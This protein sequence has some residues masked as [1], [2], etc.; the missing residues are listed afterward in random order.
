MHKSLD[1]LHE[2]FPTLVTIFT[3]AFHEKVTQNSQLATDASVWLKEYMGWPYDRVDNTLTDVFNKMRP[4]YDFLECK[5]LL[6]MSKVFLQNVTFNENGTISEAIGR[7][8]F[9]AKE[10][11][12]LS[13][14][15]TF[16]KVLQQKIEPF[17]NDLEKIPYIH[18]HLQT[19]WE[20]RSIDALYK[21]IEKLLP[22]KFRQSLTDRISIYPGS[23]VIK[24]TVLDYTADSLIKYAQGKLQFMHL[25]GIFSL[26]INDHAVLQEDENINFTF[27][28]ALHEAVT[29]GHNEAVEFLLQLETVNIDHTNEEGKTAL[30]LACERGHD[31]IVHSLLSAEA[32]V[33]LQD[34][35]GWT[36]LMR[37]SEH[38]HISII[39]MLLQANANPQLKKSNGSNALMIASG[40]GNYEVVELLISIGVDYKYQRE[41][42]WNAFMFACQKGHTQIVE[43]L[44]KEQVD[45]NVQNKDGWNAFMSACKNG[46]TQIVE[47][48][49]KEQVDPNVQKEDGCNAFM[50]ACQNGHTQ[51]V[52]LLLKE[53]VDPNVQKEDGCNA[54]M[55]ACQNGHTQIVELLLKE[56]VDPNIQK[57]DGWNAFMFACQKGH[58]QIVELLLKEQVD[59]NVQDKDGW[60]AFMSACQNGHTQIVELLLKEQ[61]DP[62][63]QDKD[64]VNA[65]MLA[66]QNGHTQIVELLLKEQVDP[67]VQ[68]KDGVNAFMVACLNGC[69]Q[70]VELLLKEQV[71]PNVQN[72]DGVNAFMLACLNGCTQIV[73]LLLK[74][75]VDPNVQN[76]DGVNAFMVACLNG[77]TQIVELLLKEQVDPNVQ[78]KDGWNAFMVACENGRTQIV[79][80]LLKEQVD[81]NV[82]NKD[83]WNAFMVACLNGRT[84]IVELLLKEQVDPNVQNKDGVNAFMS[85]CQN[86]HIQIVEQLLKE[87][88]D[89]NVQK[90]DGWNA[91]MLACLNGHTQIVELLLK[92]QVDPNVQDKDGWNAFMSA[93]K[94]G[95]TQIVE[96]LL[97]EQVDPN[98]QKE[99][100][101]NAFMSSCKNGHTQ[102]VELLLKEQVDPNVQ[103]EDGW[104][105]FMLACKN[106]HTQIVELLLK[107]QVDP[108]VK[109]L[110]GT[111]A[112][113][114]ACMMETDNSEIVELLLKAGA[115]PNVQVESA[116][117]P[118]ING[119]TALIDVCMHGHLRTVQLL[120][121]AGANPNLKL[122]MIEVSPLHFAVTLGYP[123]ILK[124][125]IE[126]GANVNDCIAANPQFISSG[127]SITLSITGSPTMSI[128]SPKSADATLNV[129]T[130]FGNLSITFS[131]KQLR[132][133]LIQ[134]A[135]GLLC[136]KEATGKI[137]ESMKSMITNIFKLP[138]EG[139]ISSQELLKVM[140]EKIAGD[141]QLEIL[142]MLSLIC[143][144]NDP[145]TLV[146]A[147]MSGSTKVVDLL[148]KAGYDPLKPLSSSKFFQQVIQS[149]QQLAMLELPCP[150]LYTACAFGQLKVVQLFLNVTDSKSVQCT[151]LCEIACD[152]GHWD[153]LESLLQSTKNNDNTALHYVLSSDNQMITN[154]RLDIIQLFLKNN[155]NVNARDSDGLTPLMIASS[156]G[157]TEAVLLLLE[158]TDLNLKD[159]SGMTALMYAC[160]NGHCGIVEV[161][162]KTNNV[163]TT[164]IDRRGLSAL[165]HA[166]FGQHNDT[167]HVFLSYY[168]PSEEEIRRALVS[169]CCRGHMELIGFFINKLMLTKL[170]SNVVAACMSDD[171]DYISRAILL[172]PD[173]PL[174]ESTGLTPLMLATSC[175]SVGVVQ[176]LV[177]F[178][179]D[180]NKQDRYLKYSPLLYAV[181]GSKSVAMVQYLLDHGANVNVITTDGQTPL[182]IAILKKQNDI[183]KL[184][185]SRGGTTYSSPMGSK[186]K[187]DQ[188]SEHTKAQI[189]KAVVTDIILPCLAGGLST[190]NRL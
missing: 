95:H 185:Q 47:L 34:N 78:N 149:P 173:K 41:D 33:N 131:I 143:P 79:E 134:Y 18:I 13:T 168:E 77:R 52:E 74:E 19:D 31:D 55:L 43:L 20:E 73:E 183:A 30:M 159:S 56:Q 174:V 22:G 123:M 60:N 63:V 169:A 35:N 86:G 107:E 6:D 93:C 40:Y 113:K 165:S 146:F 28:L 186:V 137:A 144:D 99:D 69:T 152:C 1:E 12:K 42:G 130:N 37:A 88:V 36:A 27:E 70:I 108:N 25:I 23:I 97:K 84:Q 181:S 39:N 148:L 68:N 7:H 66:C 172:Q 50:L 118:F 65:F 175:G 161:L 45:P 122:R 5:L 91:F 64:G 81:P 94:N 157:F 117:E 87:Q 147:A 124:E 61:V 103:K 125:L 120:L 10:L 48:L 153:I 49:L 160:R 156:K 71:D 96:L 164:I 111:T 189:L 104:N 58:T 44:L 101:W 154:N 100:G 109:S 150:S 138:E 139:D 38:N 132:F 11:R 145:A 188:I 9:K 85:A 190:F 59:P 98:V 83:G 179:A 110:N 102:I 46:H 158:K 151:S 26:Y 177:E 57:E 51:I 32:N 128:T 167:V 155:V 16:R 106:G 72:K 90:E 142:Q 135:V 162:L 15:S 82:Q 29:A 67:N 127:S 112:L 129:T 180:V 105:A 140:T 75:Q 182:D 53:Q 4:Y 121:K 178:E 62:N 3:R 24:L 119:S 114:A 133:S 126:A 54:F 116:T 166:V 136:M 92:E 80:L 8:S 170:E 187:E 115:D 2:N 17:D 14:I 89:P 176:E 163:D 76:K 141:G 171:E 21:L 184:L